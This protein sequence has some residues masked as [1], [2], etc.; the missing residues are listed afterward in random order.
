MDIIL[1]D[2]N[3]YFLNFLYD[4][5]ANYLKSKELSF[6][7]RQFN[8]GEELLKHNLD[9]VD[10]IF[11]DII[12]DKLDGIQLA[13][14]LRKRNPDFILVFVSSYIEYAHLGY[15]VKA[16]RYILKE[17]VDNLF[18]DMMDAILC[19][20]GYFRTEITLDFSFGAETFFT[21]NLIY[22]ESKLHTVCFHFHGKTR[23]LYSTLDSIQNILPIEEF[24]R[25]H[26]SYLVNIWHLIDIKNYTAF[27]DNGIELPVSQKRF[28][29]AKKKLFIHKRESMKI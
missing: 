4:K 6:K 9:Q 19:E 2:D 29:E 7:I 5:L 28:A 14:R 15:E 21:D 20:K 13:R 27:L 17:D 16:F 25:I 11:L 18:D 10:I 1:C 24:V 22:A 23:H 26:K 3:E 12:I 8:S